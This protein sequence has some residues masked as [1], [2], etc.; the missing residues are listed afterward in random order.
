MRH[1]SISQRM[2]YMLGIVL[3]LSILSMF[4]ILLQK[5]ETLKVEKTRDSVHELSETLRE[6]IMFAMAGGVTDISPFIL[7]MKKNQNIR[8]LRVI[9]TN[10][11]R[12]DSELKFDTKEK[13][14]LSTRKPE[15]TNE[16]FKGEDVVSS[17]EL[18]PS[19]ETCTSCHVSQTGDPLAVVSIRYTMASTNATIASQRLEALIMGI[20]VLLFVFFVVRHFLNKYILK[21]QSRRSF[22]RSFVSFA[23]MTMESVFSLFTAYP[24]TTAAAPAWAGQT[25]RHVPHRVHSPSSMVTRCSS[26]LKARPGQSKVSTQVL[27]PVQSSMNTAGS[28]PRSSFVCERRRHSLR[29]IIT[30]GPF[31]APW[32]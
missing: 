28:K 16:V 19:N 24:G 4:F 32:R 7:Q 20:A 15:F 1:L 23:I 13:E 2:N 5:E 8:E 31:A 22:K 21:D 10:L 29:A 9:P 6:S 30:A 11:I 26:S 12:P 18:L 17:I 25:L 27:Q 14:V 3:L